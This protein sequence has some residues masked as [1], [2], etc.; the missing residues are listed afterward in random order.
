MYRPAPLDLVEHGRILA[1]VQ[2]DAGHR[3]IVDQ[4]DWIGGGNV[5]VRV[6]IDGGATWTELDDF[7]P[8][9]AWAFVRPMWDG[10]LTYLIMVDEVTAD[11]GMFRSTDGGASW[12]R[13]TGIAGD[14]NWDTTKNGFRAEY[15]LGAWWFERDNAANDNALFKST[16]NGDNWT[17]FY[18]NVN[19]FDYLIDPDHGLLIYNSIGATGGMFQSSDGTTAPASVL[20]HAA[21]PWA[22][23][24]VRDRLFVDPNGNLFGFMGLTGALAPYYN[25][26]KTD[27]TS[28]NAATVIT[29][30]DQSGVQG[31]AVSGS[32][33]WLWDGVHTIRRGFN[34]AFTD[35]ATAWW[36]ID[37]TSWAGAP[38]NKLSN[39]SANG[40]FGSFNSIQ[41]GQD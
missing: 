35:T 13:V 39:L 33:K 6:S 38:I 2:F 7:T 23:I 27:I 8:L 29:P 18:T 24:D 12:V 26:D 16:D 40:A 15:G 5:I 28:W 36:T 19:D 14:G 17:Q 1:D 22:G 31:W 20:T 32:G 25:D 37:G 9:N 10:N 34:S 4:V 41:Y 3:I 11:D 30:V 21:A